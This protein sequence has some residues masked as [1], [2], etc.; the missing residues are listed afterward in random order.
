MSLIVVRL[1]GRIGRQA[2]PVSAETTGEHV[3]ITNPWHA[4]SILPRPGA[5]EPA[6]SIA[7]KRFLSSEEPPPLPLEGCTAATCTCRYN[8]HSDRRAPRREA[9]TTAASNAHPRR[10]ADD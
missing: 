3:R 5:C 4:V 1:R 2:P 7:G 6:R 8:H 10:R 9:G